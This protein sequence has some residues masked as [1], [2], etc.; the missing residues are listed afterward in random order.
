MIDERPETAQSMG[1]PTFAE[2]E[3]M[4]P[5]EET[6]AECYGLRLVVPERPPAT[7]LVFGSGALENAQQKEGRPRL[8]PKAAVADAPER[9]PLFSP[10]QTLNRWAELDRELLERLG[11]SV[12]DA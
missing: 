5:A 9:V 10:A 6:E 2:T 8:P 1:E 12:I 7:T 3:T 11:W 4:S